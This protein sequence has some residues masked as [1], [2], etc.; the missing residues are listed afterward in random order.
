MFQEVGQHKVSLLLK[1]VLDSM[2]LSRLLG[3]LVSCQDLLPWAQFCKRP[4]QLDLRPFLGQIEEKQRS[5]LVSSR[6]YLG[7]RTDWCG[8]Q[9]WRFLPIWWLL[10]MPVSWNGGGETFSGSSCTGKAGEKIT[11]ILNK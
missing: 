10:Q 11:N 6:A 3:M 1:R 9:A 7:A 4:L 5:P 8:G 2:L